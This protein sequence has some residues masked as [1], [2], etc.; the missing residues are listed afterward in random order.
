M[1]VLMI[2]KRYKPHIGGV[3]KHLENLIPCLVN[4]NYDIDLL[5]ENYD[6]KQLEYEKINK[7]F[8]VYRFSIFQLKYIGLVILWIKLLFQY[9]RLVKK[10]DIIHIHDV[11][12]WYLPFRV[13]FWKKPVYITFH[14][15]ESYPIKSVAFIFR[16]LAE[17]LTRGNICVG[18]FIQRWYKTKADKIIYGAVAQNIKPTNKILYDVTCMGRMDEQT[19]VLDYYKA[20]KNIKKSNKDIRCL[21]VGDGPFRHI[22][23]KDFKVT[24]FVQDPLVFM[25]NSKV[26]LVSRYLSLLEAFMCKRAVVG[27]YDNPIKEDY[28]KMSP[29]SKYIDIG[30]SSYELEKYI[31]S[32]LKTPNFKRIDDAYKFAR[33]MSWKKLSDDYIKLWHM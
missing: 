8:N 5:T 32:N 22:I 25:K 14:G 7:N 28:L 29:F 12:I 31:L 17:L 26:I 4:N 23:E 21:F 33:T 10:A 6:N 3:E 9:T 1:R 19:G 16:K 2:A 15:Y 13:I 30:K 18:E 27:T 24:G 20:L 11:F